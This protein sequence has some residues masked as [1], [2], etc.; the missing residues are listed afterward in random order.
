MLTLL[1]RAGVMAGLLAVV[2]QV[3]EKAVEAYQSAVN[4]VVAQ[5]DAFERQLYSSGGAAAHR[6]RPAAAAG[7][8]GESW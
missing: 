1:M 5:V 2:V 7:T 8:R 3:V 4:Q 6:M